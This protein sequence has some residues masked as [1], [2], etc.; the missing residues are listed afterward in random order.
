MTDRE[1]RITRDSLRAIVRGV[2]GSSPFRVKGIAYRGALADYERVVPGGYRAMV[3]N[4]DNETLR[5]FMTQPFLASAW[6]DVMPFPA[7]DAIA[8]RLSGQSLAQ[9]VRG[10]SARQAREELG[11]I[12]S[13]FLKIL[14]PTLVGQY[15]PRIAAQYH[16][17]GTLE[18]RVDSPLSVIV[19]RT[20]VPDDLVDW[21]NLV[22]LQYL[23]V[24]LELSGAQGV[25]LRHLG[26]EAD[27][28]RAGYLLSRISVKI[29]W[30]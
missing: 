12:Y 16:D 6:Y 13:M 14:S 28:E 4:A 15:L 30:R 1:R 8:A 3:D 24:A 23:S 11:G 18:S 20:G 25:Q 22:A 27:G 7:V 26:R 5:N 2:P 17:F 29:H 19:T 9:F 21:L 10:A